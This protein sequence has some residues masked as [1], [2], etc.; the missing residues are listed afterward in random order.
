M[1]TLNATI[2]SQSPWTASFVGTLTGVPDGA[3][4]FRALT[5]F[6]SHDRPI[7]VTHPVQVSNGIGVV[8]G[9]GYPC[10][11]HS[12]LDAAGAVIAQAAGWNGPG[13]ACA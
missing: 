11:W 3:Y 1:L 7:Y 5:G 13:I 2:I 12:I 10:T 9:E 8:T 4:T 6:D